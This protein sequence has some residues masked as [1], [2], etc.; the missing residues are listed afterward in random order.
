MRQITATNIKH[1]LTT[2]QQVALIHYKKGAA[3]KKI[4][5]AFE[6][7][8]WNEI[9]QG[10]KDAISQLVD[11]WE[12]IIVSVIERQ[13]GSSYISGIS[14]S[15]IEK[16]FNVAKENLTVLAEKELSSTNKERFFRFGVWYIKQ[17]ML[18]S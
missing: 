16:I 9:R 3:A 14:S 18:R 17:A 12:Y 8:L 5:P 2:K 1:R 11:S 15:S 4:K 6:I 13:I 10:N 7:Y